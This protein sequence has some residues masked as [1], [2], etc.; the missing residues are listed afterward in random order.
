MSYEQNAK[1]YLKAQSKAIA[2][3]A[4]I[5]SRHGGVD[6]V[7]Q[8]RVAVRRARVALW[9]LK[10]KSNE[11][12]YKKL[13][14]NLQRIGKALGKVR[15]LDVAI[16]DADDYG[17]DSSQLTARR[18]TSRKKLRKKINRKQRQN[19]ALL[20]RSFDVATLSRSPDL[21]K[22]RDNLRVRLNRNLK[23]HINEQTKLHRLRVAM[24]K[25]RYSLEALGKPVDPIKRLQNILGDAH[26]LEILQALV[27]KNRKVIVDQNSLNDKAVCLVKP[28][29]RFAIAQL[30]VP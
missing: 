9:I 23:R 21:M 29:L 11:I 26:D 10:D 15:E 19:L 24:K 13:S 6:H 30:G 3:L 27:G 25:I 5:V 22:S 17:I 1:K 12:Q 8:L 14:Q 18:D 20:F 28:T 2:R 4:P 7:H 16:Q